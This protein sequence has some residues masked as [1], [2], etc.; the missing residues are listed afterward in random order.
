MREEKGGAGFIDPSSD[1]SGSGSQLG[2]MEI[3][4]FFGGGKAQVGRR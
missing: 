3:V 2:Q 4:K 1:N